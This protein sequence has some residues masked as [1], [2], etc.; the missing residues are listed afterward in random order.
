[1][2]GMRRLLTWKLSFKTITQNSELYFHNSQFLDNKKRQL[3]GSK[4]LP[5]SILFQ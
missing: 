1:M 3:S 5:L 2:V 4:G